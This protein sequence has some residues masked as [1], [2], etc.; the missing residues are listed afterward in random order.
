M[1]PITWIAAITVLTMVTSGTRDIS[2]ILK[3]KEAPTLEKY[4]MRHEKGH[5][6]GD[7]MTRLKEPKKSGKAAG[8]L[9][10]WR[11]A[12][13]ENA[14][15]YAAEKSKNRGDRRVQWYRDHGRHVED[16]AWH[17]KQQHKIR[18]QQEKLQD[19]K[20]KK[21]LAER[22][23]E[24]D[25][26]QQP[27]PE[28]EPAGPL[29]VEFPKVEDFPARPA[30][31]EKPGQQPEEPAKPDLQPVAD[32]DE[33]R[34]RKDDS[35][36][37]D[38]QNTDSEPTNTTDKPAADAAATNAGG[39]MYAREAEDLQRRADDIASY[40]RDLTEFADG[41][42]TDWG[43]EVVGPVQEMDEP[44]LTAENELLVVAN[45]VK[46]QGDAAAEAYE[47][48]PFAPDRDVLV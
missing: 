31:N 14:A 46:Q 15:N 47:Q 40:R 1:D 37:S 18:K 9:T 30:Q 43:T 7:A 38:N 10:V 27:A 21:G 19:F 32:L 25:P 6:L 36:S 33:H 28:S 8:P 5:N 24:S 3:G 34:S 41:L 13:V 48:A 2:S 39:N 35:A 26:Q 44:L 17:A 45:L 29:K 42:S 4:R 11:R 20:V 23:P 12:V 16:E 22:E